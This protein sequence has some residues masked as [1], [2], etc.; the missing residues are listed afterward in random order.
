MT[1][2]K[3]QR[4]RIVACGVLWV[5]ITRIQLHSD[6]DSRIHWVEDRALPWGRLKGKDTG[7]VFVGRIEEAA[8]I[9]KEQREFDAKWRDTDSVEV[10][11]R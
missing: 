4:W 2:A 9:D 11:Y 8:R 7:S 10:R 6:G 3:G 5:R 1:L